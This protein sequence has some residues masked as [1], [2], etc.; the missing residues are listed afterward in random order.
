MQD[1]VLRTYATKYFPHCNIFTTLH[2]VCF[3]Y[4]LPIYEIKRIWSPC[5]CLLRDFN[6][7]RNAIDVAMTLLYAIVINP[8]LHEYSCQA[9]LTMNTHIDKRSRLYLE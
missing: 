3:M 2:T 8:F 5:S 4:G 6:R 1:K 9:P 7:K